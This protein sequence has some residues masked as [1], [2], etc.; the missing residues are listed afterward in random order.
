M[1]QDDGRSHQQGLEDGFYSPTRAELREKIAEAERARSEQM[2]ALAEAS[3]IT[4]VDMLVVLG[5]GCEALAALTLYPLVAVAWAD[6][7]TD[8]HER[9]SVLEAGESS[10]IHAGSTNYLLLTDWLDHQPPGALLLAAWK[11]LVGELCAEMDDTA[12]DSFRTQILE[13]AR[14]V[15]NASGAFLALD[16]TSGSEQRILDDLASAF[17]SRS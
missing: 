11:G 9:E 13:R 6:G 8:R 1:S 14:A 17:D 16:K 4:N 7:K 5:V 12:R 2:E 10:G 3:G 15:A